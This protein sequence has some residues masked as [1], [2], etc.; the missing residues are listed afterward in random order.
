MTEGAIAGLDPGR[1]KCGLVLTDP[2]RRRIVIALVL[3]PEQAG[4]ALEQW[5]GAG[6]GAVVLGNGTGSG[7][8]RDRLEP[9]LPVLLVEEGGSTLAARQRYWQL[10][11]PRGWRRLLPRG[12]RL[13]PR[14]I[15]DVVAQLLVEQWLGHPLRRDGST[16]LRT[17]PGR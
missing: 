11:P 16:R 1:S 10:E 2:P 12:L 3:P 14:D 7:V 6:V 9:R 17:M 8:W 15:D 5:I 13:P 4:A